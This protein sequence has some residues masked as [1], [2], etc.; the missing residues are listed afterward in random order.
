MHT[1]PNP[2]CS[3]W[4][5]HEWLKAD[6][7]PDSPPPPD[8]DCFTRPCQMLC[9]GFILRGLSNPGSLLAPSGSFQLRVVFGTLRV[10]PT[11]GRFW[12]P[13]G[14]SN[15]GSFLVPSRFFQLRVIIGTVRVFPN[16]RLL[17]VTLESTFVSADPSWYRVVLSGLTEILA[18][19]A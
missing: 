11:Q 10:F 9:F 3:R 8:P 18:I 1:P 5:D 2:T 12:H 14:L 19:L 13:Q 16:L 4:Y 6:Y 7:K 15:S 17:T